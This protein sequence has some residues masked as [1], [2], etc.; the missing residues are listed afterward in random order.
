MCKSPE[1]DARW[2]RRNLMDIGVK[3]FSRHVIWYFRE[4]PAKVQ[5]IY[6]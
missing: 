1:S 3:A 6:N 2:R 5:Q 4:E